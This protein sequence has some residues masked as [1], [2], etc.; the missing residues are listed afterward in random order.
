LSSARITELGDS[1]RLP[2]LHPC[3]VH[4]RNRA[5]DRRMNV[6][7]LVL[8]GT[9]VRLRWRD[10]VVDVP[11]AQHV[12]EVGASA[13]ILA[14]SA[15][16]MALITG[17]PRAHL[18]PRALQQVLLADALHPVVE[19]LESSLQRRFQWTMGDVDGSNG[20]NGAADPGD[21][22][23]FTVS[24]VDG[25]ASGC[26]YVRFDAPEALDG[27]LPALRALPART[28]VSA[29]DWPPG[30]DRLRFTFGFT[31]GTTSIRLREARA[32]ERG[33]IVAVDGWCPSGSG[34]RVTAR[35]GGR[36]PTLLGMAE[37][38]SITLTQK[39]LPM[40]ADPLGHATEA[41][42]VDAAPI[43]RLD[44]M[45]VLLRFEVGD[46]TLT[47]GELRNLGP[48]HV[49]ELPHPLNRSPVRILAHGNPL[50]RGHLVAVGDRLGVRV[51]EFAP[52]QA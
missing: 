20:S 44:D 24:V 49:F 18:L 26:G 41:D 51:S 25:D 16:A 40:N 7:R 4:A 5:F 23:A 42:A 15:P 13:G 6:P 10:T 21:D 52:G 8:R 28:T 35:P 48:G 33:D 46:L 34:L 1:R 12:F 38:S 11:Y 30:L 3:A 17:E 39:E 36:G 2:R 37:G 43:D 9:P 45:E 32:I 47:L 50:G 19:M 14:L 29:A 31:V 22:L 27:L